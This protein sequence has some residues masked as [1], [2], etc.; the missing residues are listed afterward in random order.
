MYYSGSSDAT[1]HIEYVG[2][3]SKHWEDDFLI[4]SPVDTLTGGS[5]DET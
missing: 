5:E 4:S 1:I 3:V 2:D